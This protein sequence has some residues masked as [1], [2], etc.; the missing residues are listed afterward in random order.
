MLRI[1]L[2]WGN[3]GAAPPYSPI[4]GAARSAVPPIINRYPT[5][6]HCHIA[7]FQHDNAAS[8]GGEIIKR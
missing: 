6:K 1:R 3:T 5:Q 4:S 7:T 2:K 8:G